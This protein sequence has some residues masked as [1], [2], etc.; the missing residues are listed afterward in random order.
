MT[1]LKTSEGRVGQDRTRWRAARKAE[2]DV[3]SNLSRVPALGKGFGKGSGCLQE[4]RNHRGNRPYLDHSQIARHQGM[5]RGMWQGGGHGGVERGAGAFGNRP[6][7]DDP[8]D[9]PRLRGQP[10]LALVGNRGRVTADLPGVGSGGTVRSDCGSS[11]EILLGDTRVDN[12]NNS[13][14]GTK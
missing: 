2:P 6:T 8:T 14:I 9:A 11:E 1:F 5:V 10:G 4:D 13:T 12:Q 3:E 7:S